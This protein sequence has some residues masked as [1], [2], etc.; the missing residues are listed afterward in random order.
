MAKKESHSLASLTSKG[1]AL[2]HAGSDATRTHSEFKYWDD[3]VAEWFD[4]RPFKS[5]VRYVYRGFDPGAQRPV[6][7][8]NRLDEMERTLYPGC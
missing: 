7:P 1:R 8:I 2:L 6:D 4:E 3:D 5:A